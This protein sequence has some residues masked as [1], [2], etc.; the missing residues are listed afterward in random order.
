M[1]LIEDLRAQAER[2]ESYFRAYL[3]KEDI[4][5][6]ERTWQLATDAQALD[7]FVKS[8]WFLGW[9][10]DDLRTNELAPALEP[11][12]SAVFDLSRGI[13]DAES[14][15][16]A[17]WLALDRLRMDRLVGCLARVPRPDNDS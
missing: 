8:A 4:V 1:R 15:V 7:A 17:T 16:A 13:A 14:R 3:I 5:R 6:L 10:P 11:F 12:L 9:T 2:E